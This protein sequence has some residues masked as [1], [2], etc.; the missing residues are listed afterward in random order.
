MLVCVSSV[1]CLMMFVVMSGSR[2]CVVVV[3]CCGDD[4]C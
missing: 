4:L 3:S 1:L 2:L